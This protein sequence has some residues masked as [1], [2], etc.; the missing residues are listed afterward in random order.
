MKFFI[1]F[2]M[3]PIFRLLA[4]LLLLHGLATGSSAA[5][6]SN[7]PNVLWITSED[8]SPYLGCYGDEL[9]NTP[10]LVASMFQMNFSCPTQGF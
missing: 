5:A 9:A 2:A 7:R 3:E 10:N 1:T 8:N 6:D 4:A